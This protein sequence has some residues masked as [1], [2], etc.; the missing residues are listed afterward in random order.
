MITNVLERLDAKCFCLM[1]NGRLV[2][3]LTC[4]W[5]SLNLCAQHFMGKVYLLSV[6]YV[7]LYFS[8]AVSGIDAPP[9]FSPAKKYS[10]I[11]GLMVGNL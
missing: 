6:L 2:G 9:S 1:Q 10:D 11:T 4:P 5:G 8:F 3:S 7:S